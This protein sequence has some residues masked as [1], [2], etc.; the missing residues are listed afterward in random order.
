VRIPAGQTQVAFTLSAADNTALDGTRNVNVTAAAN[1]FSPASRSVVVRDN[2]VATYRFAALTDIVNVSKPMNLSVSA[3]DVEGNTIP[4]FSA[5]VNLSVVSANG[6]AQALTPATVNV[7][8]TTG[9]SGTVTFPALTDSPVT[10]RASD[11]DGTSG[12]SPSVDIMRTL[13]LVTADIIWDAARERLYASVPATASGPY[14]N[15]VVSIN[16]VTMEITGSVATNQD[17]GQMALT[18]GGEYLYVALK[19]NGAIAKVDPAA[20]AVISTFPVGT[21]PSYGTLY[22]EDLCTVAG[23]PDV[24]IVSQFRK[25]V[26]PRHNGVAAYDNGV[27]RPVKTQDHTGSNI[28]EPSADPTIFFGYN[29]ET[30]EFGFRRLKLSANGLTQMQVDGSLFSGFSADM[31]S[32]GDRVYS[33]SGVAVDG[34]L[35]KR[36]GTFSASGFVFPD[37]GFAR[38][39]YLE[40]KSSFSSSYEALS[41]HD[42]ATFSLVR[43]LT[44]APVNALGSLVRWGRKRAGLSH[45]RQCCADWQQT[46]GAE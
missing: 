4:N 17:P 10:L 2:D 37:S 42:P 8:G 25:S 16:P 1:T 26:S 23:Q 5:N 9:W 13:G 28:I 27:V 45:G 39:Y 22:A 3:V 30:T 24:V 7:T 44:M 29:T 33:T 19:A 11:G 15:K 20:M 46:A 14:A 43:R 31:R 38:V 36:V 40:P 18:S 12:E 32:N 6:T 34:A 35:M 21:D 41:A